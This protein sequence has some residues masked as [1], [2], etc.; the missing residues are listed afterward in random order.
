MLRNLITDR[1]AQD[2]VRGKQKINKTMKRTFSVHR[3]PFTLRDPFSV[4]RKRLIVNGKSIVNSKLLMVN[5]TGKG[6]W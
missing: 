2:L 5:G 4:Y 6:V 3:F 1:S